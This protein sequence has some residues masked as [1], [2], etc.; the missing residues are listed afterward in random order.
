MN[1]LIAAIIMLAAVGLA[2]GDQYRYYSSGYYQQPY[3][4]IPS[5]G[6]GFQGA[7]G[8][9]DIVEELRLLRKQNEVLIQEIR[10]MKQSKATAGLPAHEQ[11]IIARC[12]SCHEAA[13]AGQKGHS[14]TLVSNNRLV[15]LTPELKLEIIR[16]THGSGDP[17]YDM[18]LNQPLLDKDE[19]AVLV[20]GMTQRARRGSPKPE[21]IQLPKDDKE[22]KK[23]Q[24]K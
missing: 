23:V 19:M 20:D 16:R 9:G 10:A 11:L 7:S 15:D 17:A 2:S 14:L 18:P 13:V 4:L 21:V 22:P 6:A 5:Y 24:D 12:A 3:I 1:K 8:T